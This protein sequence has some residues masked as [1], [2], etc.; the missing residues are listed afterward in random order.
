MSNPDSKNI[1]EV[2]AQWAA[3]SISGDFSDGDRRALQRWL[4]ANPSH[5]QAFDQ[6]IEIAEQASDIADLIREDTLVR[7]LEKFS[8]ESTNRRSWWVAG[9]AMAASIAAAGLFF[10]QSAPDI[11]NGWREFATARGETKEVRLA[12][13]SLVTLNTDTELRILM[14][15]AERRIELSKGEALFDV[16]RDND[17]KF[18]VASKAADTIVRGTRFNV[19]QTTND[20]IVSVLSGVVEVDP[21]AD[22]KNALPV[23]LIAGH[24]VVVHSSGAHDPVVAF[25]PDIVSAWRRG[26]ERYENQRLA[27]VVSDLNRYFDRPIV[28]R[29]VA[30]EN[31]PV[32]GGF[33][34]TN[35]ALV[36]QALSAALSI[37]ASNGP[38]G[39]I[40]LEADG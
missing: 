13:G 14:T 36:V 5:A 9:P 18:V 37:R 31:L 33:D 8:R 21:I 24:A 10:F 35:Q 19:E 28:I 32:T 11:D 26:F 12:D 27:Y 39:E 30:L 38:N 25:N 22:E 20:T 3:R 40:Y 34:V 23:T 7:D 15:D 16:V 2:A 4:Q 1:D 29:D 6:Y 17:R